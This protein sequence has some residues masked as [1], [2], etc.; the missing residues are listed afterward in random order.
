M[1]V[2]NAKGA[3]LSLI[4]SV[5]LALIIIGS[6]LFYLTKIIGGA[7][8]VGS[9]T[10]AG[11]VSAAKQLESVT[12]DLNK[13]A[14]KFKNGAVPLE[15]SG[16][17]VNSIT[18]AP[19]PNTSLYNIYAY[20]RA[21]GAAL[22]VCANA[23][24]EASQGSTSAIADAGNTVADLQVIGDGLTAEMQ[25]ALTADGRSSSAT[26]T[27]WQA[28]ATTAA[29]NN[30]NCMGPK[31]SSTANVVSI[32]RAY[33][34]GNPLTQTGKTNIYFNSKLLSSP[35]GP[36][37][38]ELT[39]GGEPSRSGVVSGTPPSYALTALNADAFQS[40]QPFIPGYQGFSFGGKK[41]YAV[42]VNPAQ[43]P[44][45]INQERFNLGATAS[46]ALPHT[47]F[48]CIQT[49]T[50]T[51]ET[52][53]TNLFIT[54]IASAVIGSMSNA[55]PAVLPHAFILLTNDH[56]YKYNAEAVVGALTPAALNQ[57]PAGA[58]GTGIFNN[59]LYEDTAD[60]G[61]RQIDVFASKHPYDSGPYGGVVFGV[62]AG[63][64]F[65][66]PDNPDSSKVDIA[67]SNL[68]TQLDWRWNYCWTP[69]DK[70]SSYL[71]S[72][73]TVGADKFGHDPELDPT[74][75][76]LSNNPGDP[77]NR[78][79][80]AIATPG[81]FCYKWMLWQPNKN[82]RIAPKPP[83][84][85][86][87]T[88]DIVEASAA[89]MASITLVGNLGCHDLLYNYIGFSNPY[90]T[91]CEAP[92]LNYFEHSFGESGQIKNNTYTGDSGYPNQTT[93][94]LTALEYT[95]GLVITG[96]QDMV[97][98]NGKILAYPWTTTIPSA[99]YQF[100][101]MNGN[102]P[103]CSGSR[104]YDRNAGYAQPTNSPSIS[105][106]TNG[107]PFDL[108]N[109][110]SNGGSAS[111]PNEAVFAPNASTCPGS[112]DMSTATSP[113]WNSSS[114]IQGQLLQRVQEI[115]PSY[116]AT[117]LRS[118]LQTPGTNL[119]LGWSDVIFFDD[120]TSSPT[121]N[122][123][124]MAVYDPSNSATLS[125]FPS[126]LQ[127]QLK[128]WTTGGSGSL[129]VP[130]NAMDGATAAPIIC[131]NQP[132]DLT[133]MAAPGGNG[134]MGSVVDSAKGIN[135]NI[136]GDYDL[137]AQP[138]G[139]GG[140]GVNLSADGVTW[141]PNSGRNG[142]LGQLLFQQASST[143]VDGNGNPINPFTRIPS[144]MTMVS[145]ASGFTGPN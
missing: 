87:G 60:G 7:Q 86:E 114:S 71:G 100:P 47:P 119:D 99:N 79:N 128:S 115:D 22:I 135:N 54:A 53:K 3:T 109:Q 95:K 117:K 108:L 129:N 38:Q 32:N 14:S 30:T 144:G 52:N 104:K 73:P 77:N 96:W 33:V 125:N 139:S 8:Q 92:Y 4:A 2:R 75:G 97:T 91:L 12:V 89:D 36:K 78:W 93:Q 140:A 80:T 112:I 23:R 111:V 26:Q 81:S 31:A 122:S 37:L 70:S 69:N 124:T 138:F 42:N 72:H 44:H 61:G 66:G 137:H 40:E 83:Y 131:A 132:L 110:I 19:D 39:W 57:Y 25:N 56:S 120:R 127:T 64:T 133:V 55:Y 105:F 21:V 27:P 121:F 10:D 116:D 59:E 41:F 24:Y 88:Q 130:P 136:L 82:A 103:I 68:I 84:P 62:E 113:L 48:N 106:G 15:L 18:G 101:T 5:T 6:A 13:L 141:T 145:K 49:V 142:L 46:A 126:W 143:S 107:T 63:P 9:A 65:Y 76:L 28:A 17:G 11:A 98:K 123:L 43:N 118:L 134:G 74:G 50:K 1:H 102:R 20:N 67:M 45:L 94:G 58:G 34:G 29:I 51:E 16:L 35:I 85:P 90:Y